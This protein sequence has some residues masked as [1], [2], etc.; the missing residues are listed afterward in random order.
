MT[1][2]RV[3]FC[4][5]GMAIARSITTPTVLRSSFNDPQKRFKIMGDRYVEDLGDD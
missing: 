5:L 4:R 1:L 3:Y 2:T